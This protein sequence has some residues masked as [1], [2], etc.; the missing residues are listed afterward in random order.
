MLKVI[1]IIIT[2]ILLITIMGCN[3]FQKSNK[4]SDNI[5][6]TPQEILYKIV[7]KTNWLVAL[8]IIGASLSMA[9]YI[10]GSKTAVPI[11]IGSLT[12][13]GLT[14]A[15]VRY[16]TWFAGGSI[17]AAV[18]IFGATV[19]KKN[20]ALK[21]IITGVQRLKDATLKGGVLTKDDANEILTEQQNPDTTRLVLKTKDMLKL[22]GKL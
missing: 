19:I 9:A 3:C 6:D 20:V 15:T 17:I 2:I 21:Q 16:A 7:Y 10:N 5:P 12:A 4:T 18:L 13:L 8:S 11:G 14:L 22:K 1:T